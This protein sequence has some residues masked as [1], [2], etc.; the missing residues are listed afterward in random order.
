MDVQNA[1]LAKANNLFR[2]ELDWMRR[3]PQAR[4]SKAQYRI[5]AF[6]DL[7]KKIKATRTTG[8]VNLDVKASYIG[9]K[10]F[11]AKYV[12]K[13]YGDVKILDNFYYNFSR[14]EK[15]GIVGNNGAGKSTTMNII[16]GY[17]SSTSGYV[18]V[19][20]H[21]IL[22]EP[23]EAKK[24]IGYLPE[25]PPLYFDMTV[26]EYLNFI[27]D[28][29]K[30][31]K[32]ERKEQL[33][34]ILSMVKI[35]DMADRLIGNLSKGYKQRVGIAQA[36]VGNPDILILDEPTVGLDPNQIIEIRKLI[37]KLAENH[38]VIISSHILSEVQAVCDRVVIINKGK[39][40]AIDSIT[41]LSKKLS[42]SSKL[43]LSFKG[44]EKDVINAL[45]SIPGISN[46]VSIVANKDTS[47]S[48]VEITIAND[49]KTDVRA[50]VFY[51][52]SKGNWPILEFRSMD[53][54]LEEIF[55]SIT[56]A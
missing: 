10:I 45:R 22:E 40:A 36:L 11:E 50:S 51:A 28:L 23:E 33:A 34:S 6:H 8:T 19:N 43:S 18:K 38:T 53:P 27:C 15:L 17:L 26:L 37:R 30:V 47:I 49:S 41:D 39:V 3:Q 42:G 32:S 7:E 46:V 13:A 2:K 44:P 31:P 29:K 5:D 14:Y 54:T 25:I 24:C 1:E 55:L 48:Q 52:M 35:I 21:D 4:G 12:S 9:S 56:S 16:T 20:G